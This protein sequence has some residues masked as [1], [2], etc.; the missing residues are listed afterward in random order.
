MEDIIYNSETFLTRDFKI[1]VSGNKIWEIPN[2]IKCFQVIGEDVNT[3][4]LF[5]FAKE[6]EKENF[7]IS[8]G[9]YWKE[10]ATY[11]EYIT[12]PFIVGNKY[13]FETILKPYLLNNEVKDK[14]KK[15]EMFKKRGKK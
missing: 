8:L 15:F 6:S 10:R 12:D 4:L 5:N 9:N 3:Y 2:L 1:V 13:F 14:K 11:S 7:R